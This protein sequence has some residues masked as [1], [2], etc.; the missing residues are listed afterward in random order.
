MC[1]FDHGNDAVVLEDSRGY[2]PGLPGLTE[3]YVPGIP[4]V[5][6]GG[7][8]YPPPLLSVPPPGQTSLALQ[9]GSSHVLTLQV[10][11]LSASREVMMAEASSRQIRSLT[12]DDWE[13]GAEV[14]VVEDAEDWEAGEEEEVTTAAPCSPSGTS[15]W[16]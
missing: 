2:Q 11:L 5:P 6:G 15:R 7:I 12:T 8:S 14:G 4:A 13:A 16:S 10:I 3:P 1:K 9:L